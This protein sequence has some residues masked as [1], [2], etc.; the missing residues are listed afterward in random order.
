MNRYKVAEMVFDEIPY[1]QEQKKIS[2]LDWEAIPVLSR[3][4]VIRNLGRL[5][6]P[7]YWIMQMRGKLLE[8][9][10]SGSTGE[11]MHVYWE[12]SDYMRSL[13]PLWIYRRKFY[14]I[15]PN[16]KLVYFFSIREAGYSEIEI[17]ETGRQ[18]GFCKSGLDEKKLVEIYKKILDFQ[19]VWML[20]Q[21]SIASLLADVKRKYN[22]DNIHSLRYIECSGEIL[23][24]MVIRKLK[25]AFSCV[26]ADQYGANEI[27]SIAY[28]CPEGNLHV[29]DSNAYVEIIDDE[30]NPVDEGIEGHICV[31]SLQNKAMP[32]LRYSI[33]D[34]GILRRLECQCGRKGKVLELT[35]GRSC[36]L[37]RLKSGEMVTPFVFVRCIETINSC[38]DNIVQ[39]YQIIQKDYDKFLIKISVNEEFHDYTILEKRFFMT[40]EHKELCCCS[41]QFEY[42]SEFF[43]N[44]NSPKLRY[45]LSELM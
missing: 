45:F 12:K 6:N 11:V 5:V 28:Q 10:T 9:N 29:M 33:R 37:I 4:E 44:G 19:P 17:N 7:K 18:L 25:H 23:Q 43:W 38:F 31:T 27:G 32:L 36:D 3:Q 26:I 42:Y 30:D 2:V 39:Q 14:N 16:D 35:S 24:E 21:P 22:L 40:L 34:R 13:L 8:G 15:F 41:Y 1:Y 20:L